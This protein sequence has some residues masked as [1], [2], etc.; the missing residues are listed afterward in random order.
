MWQYSY[1]IVVFEY[2]YYFKVSEN[3]FDVFQKFSNS[4]AHQ[5]TNVHIS[6]ILI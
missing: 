3:D 2:E 5:K 4:R 6:G 1:S